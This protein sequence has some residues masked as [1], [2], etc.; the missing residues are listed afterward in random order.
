MRVCQF[1]HDG[2]HKSV[3]GHFYAAADQEELHLYST[4]AKLSFKPLPRPL[5]FQ[6]RIHCNFGV[7]NL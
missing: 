1:R 4:G 5:S 6:L 7:Q 2:N 3:S